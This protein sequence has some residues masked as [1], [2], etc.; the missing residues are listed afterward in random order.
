[1]L[2]NEQLRGMS[3]KAKIVS[4]LASD[5]AL[6]V[7]EIKEMLTLENVLPEI[8]QADEF[9][10]MSLDII[11]GSNKQMPKNI[12]MK[13][14]FKQLCPQDND[15]S[16]FLFNFLEFLVNDSPHVE[17][18]VRLEQLKG[19]D[20]GEI[21]GGSE[22]RNLYLYN[23]LSLALVDHPLDLEFIN[24]VNT[25]LMCANNNESLPKNEN[26]DVS[27]KQ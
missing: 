5:I 15:Y 26:G 13:E 2:S 19:L 16:E 10:K 1:M 6:N 18:K 23:V 20:Y 12:D 11:R 9:F 22:I 21:P 24:K 27:N 17:I 4:E 14:I 8:K 7:D 25:E 3:L